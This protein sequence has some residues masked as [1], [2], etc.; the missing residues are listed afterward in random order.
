MNSNA[1]LDYD[2]NI[3]NNK[4]KIKKT[5][6]TINRL[7]VYTAIS[8]FTCGFCTIILV[9]NPNFTL[10]A[11]QSFGVVSVS[12]TYLL[13]EKLK[14]KKLKIIHQRTLKF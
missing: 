13:Y 6:S 11:I 12:A 4:T 10:P 2:E 14:L 1:I 3:N 5:K 8:S 9:K 7:T